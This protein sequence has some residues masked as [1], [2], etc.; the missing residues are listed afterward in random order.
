M[1]CFDLPASTSLVWGSQAAPQHTGLRIKPRGLRAGYASAHPMA[2]KP[3][4]L[5][6][7]LFDFVPQGPLVGE[8]ITS[9]ASQISHNLTKNT[10]EVRIWAVHFSCRWCG[11]SRNLLLHRP[12]HSPCNHSRVFSYLPCGRV[13]HGSQLELCHLPISKSPALVSC[14]QDGRERGAGGSS[15]LSR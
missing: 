15:S 14:L 13:L 6:G 5:S 3:E 11:G 2:P 1:D 7:F 8:H 4:R 12:S 10:G 9:N